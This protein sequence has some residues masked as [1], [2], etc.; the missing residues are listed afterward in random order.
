MR[1]DIWEAVAVHPSPGCPH[2]GFLVAGPWR[3]PVALG[4][5]GIR[6]DKR[7]G[8]GATP[9]GTFRPVR[10]WWRPDHG[11]RPRT[12][13]PLRRIRPDDGWCDDPAHPRYNRPVARPFPASHEEMWRQDALYDL[14]IELDHNRRPRIARRGSAVFIH[15]ARPDYAP[16]AGCVALRRNDLRRL[17]R[18]LGPKT[19]IRIHP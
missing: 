2:R 8:D 9:R 3:L 16:T 6:A 12:A 18:H 17:L 19:R 7:E 1:R 13:L 11:P 4:R 5:T 15:L 14:V 10:V